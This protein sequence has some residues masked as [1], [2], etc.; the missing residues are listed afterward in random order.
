[1]NRIKPLA[2]F[3][4]VSLA[5]LADNNIV[6]TLKSTSV[7]G[8][9]EFTQVSIGY[10]QVSPVM[11]PEVNIT[12]PDGTR[13][14]VR[15]RKDCA[16]IRLLP[17]KYIVDARN[18]TVKKIGENLYYSMVG[19]FESDS[20]VLV[21]ENRK[22]GRY[23]M[24]LYNWKYL[25][26]NILD[27]FT[28]MVLGAGHAPEVDEWRAEG[29][30]VFR[31]ANVTMPVDAPRGIAYWDE[32]ASNP[33][34][35]GVAPDE[36]IMPAGRKNPDDAA[37][38]Y[39]RP[40]LG[41]TPEHYQALAQWYAKHPDK[42]F[43]AWLGIPWNGDCQAIKPL[44]DSVYSSPNGAILWEAYLSARNPEAPLKARFLDRGK[45]FKNVSGGSL[46]NYI[47]AL[48]TYEYMDCN[49]SVDFK[50]HLDRQF[51]LMATNPIFDNLR[52]FA[53]WAAYY[54]EPEIM[55]WFAK[56]VK[57]YGVD[58]ETTSLS[59]K[60]GYKLYPG[61]VKSPNWENV[62]DWNLCG[63][64]VLVPKGETTIKQGYIPYTTAN[65]LKMEIG[66]KSSA[67]Q[68][69][70]NLEDGRLYMVKTL[71]CTPDNPEKTEIPLEVILE[72]AEIVKSQ[73]RY[74]QDFTRRS[75]HVWNVKKTV[76]RAG[77]KPVTFKIAERA[78]ENKSATVLV[79]IVQAVPY[80]Q[81]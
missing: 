17:G 81:E 11:S 19:S 51:H 20:P 7:N 27:G 18:V 68:T 24:F 61:I 49:A 60:Y 10:V 21:T 47:V 37:M 40:G 46:K 41:F 8:G 48:A 2:I 76:F 75:P 3:L 15:T 25:R 71:Y 9:T 56:C 59:E 13:R 77:K 50:V 39:T 30:L 36:F 78:G 79:D 54:T 35:D 66:K 58:G 26:K 1:M 55:R 4:M 67:S 70:S 29:R 62:S 45:I 65:F 64:A 42:Y 23:G 72:N 6:K 69:L 44:Y 74:V 53:M 80:F 14:A 38:G 34:V 52:G 28:T 31:N 16:V 63:G 12:F 33:N 22:H 73:L 5:L 32:L 57:H 43:Y